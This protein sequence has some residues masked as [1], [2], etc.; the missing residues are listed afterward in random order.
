VRPLVSHR[1]ITDNIEALK[2]YDAVDTAVPSPDTIIQ[3]SCDKTTIEDIPD[4]N[5]LQK[6][7]TPQSFKLETIRKAYD[8]ALKDPAFKTTDDCGIVRK[9]LP[10][11]AVFVAKGEEQNIK[12]TY[13]EDIYL[14]DKLF[15]LKTTNISRSPDLKDLKNKVIVIFGGSSGIGAEMITYCKSNGARVFPFSRTLN[16]IDVSC[17]DDVQKALKEVYSQEGKI[18]CVVDTAAILS[19][20]PLKTMD[21]D[22]IQE[23]MDI[24]LKGVINVAL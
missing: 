23:M 22:R 14:L 1:I 21:Y 6:G 19:K 10:D 24:N 20:E 4:R 13:K 12:L 11:I 8:L 5:F 18:D 16:K 9:Y 3:V 17:P 2:E 7:Q 15:Q